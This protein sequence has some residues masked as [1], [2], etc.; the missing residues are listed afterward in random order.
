MTVGAPP[1][2]PQ[3]SIGR[4]NPNG[5]PTQAQLDYE[6]QFA[7]WVLSYTSS[8][9]TGIPFPTPTTL[10]GVKSA[11]APTHQFQRGIDGTGSP[12]F[13]QPSASDVSGLGS[14]ATANTVAAGS[15]TGLG[16]LATQSSVDL[17]SQVTGNLSVSHL[18][19]GIDASS[20]K[21]WRGDGTWASLASV[22]GGS[23]PQIQFNNAGLLGGFTVTGDGTLDPTSG[24][25]VI[26]KTNGVSFAS[27]ATSGS[28]SDLGT[29]TLPNAR[30][31]AVPN[32]AL[33]N[34]TISG[35]ALGSNLSALTI[36]TH[37]TGTSYNGSAG[38]TIATDAASANTAGT[39]VARDGSG[40]FSAGT[41]TV[42]VL[43][44]T[45][46]TIGTLTANTVGAAFANLSNTSNVAQL[47][48][49]GTGADNGGYAL[50]FSTNTLDLS[51][52]AAFDG[53]NWI[54]KD[55]TAQLLSLGLGTVGFFS[56]S[57]LTVGAAFSPS[58]R[59]AIDATGTVTAGTIPVARISGLGTAATVNTGTS[60]ATIPLLNGTNTWS[61][62][63]TLSAAL[64]GPSATAAPT[65]DNSGTTFTI[66]NGANT[67]LASTLCG[68]LVVSNNTD[69]GVAIF[70]LSITSGVINL[71]SSG[72]GWTTGT[73]PGAGL[74]S[75][76]WNGSA[77][78]IYNN[79]GASKV[80]SVATVRTH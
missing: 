73:T 17:A 1:L 19:S 5:T 71:V 45:T 33:A 57:G 43:N 36:G 50:G 41:A 37:L 40:N 48:L 2:P 31:S 62:T 64:V 65:I 3:P 66:A 32:S 30:L 80:Y 15:V 77:Y 58:Q 69:G 10:G 61:G 44:A 4:V 52:G 18:N 23:P 25:L 16:A 74:S 60:G 34:S 63:Q 70:L 13:A 49:S 26:T 79:V 7:A 35:I 12:L 78:A 59:F 29:G 54:A 11:T 72:G 38:V 21:F 51:G 53:T 75:I 9:V 47:H 56:N 55:T 8:L 76:G 39:I 22:P 27:V 20:S 6:R 46:A 42:T 68:M 24:A 14:L 28:A 67:V